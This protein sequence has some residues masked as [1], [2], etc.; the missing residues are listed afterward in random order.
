MDVWIKDLYNIL[1]LLKWEFLNNLYF[2]KR[3]NYK[4][5]ICLWFKKKNKKYINSIEIY[6]VKNRGFLFLNFY[7]LCFR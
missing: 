2:N 7:G 3:I 1:M 6:N 4:G 5:N